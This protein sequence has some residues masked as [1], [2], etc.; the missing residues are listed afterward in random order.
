MHSKF[1]LQLRA[2]GVFNL[3][4]DALKGVF[5]FNCNQR[6]YVP[7]WTRKRLAPLTAI[8]KDYL[9]SGIKSEISKWP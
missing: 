2:V 5:V 1:C 9:L 3:V 4:V 8:R 7:M 6:W